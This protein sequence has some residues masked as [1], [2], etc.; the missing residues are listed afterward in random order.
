MKKS[1]MLLTYLLSLTVQAETLN[2]LWI[3]NSLTTANSMPKLLTEVVNKNPTGVRINSV[4]STAGGSDWSFH[5]G[6]PVDAVLKQ[7]LPSPTLP[8]LGKKGLFDWVIIQTV[9][10]PDKRYRFHEFGDELIG[11]IRSTGAEPLIYCAMS[12]SS[13]YKN[14]SHQYVYK[15][16]DREKNITNHEELARRH[17]AV[18]APIGEAWKIAQE[19]RPNFDLFVK[20]GIHPNPIGSYLTV[21]V[22]YSVFTGK[23]PIGIDLPHYYKLQTG[24]SNVDGSTEVTLSDEQATFL[25]ECAQ[26][27]MDE[28]RANGFRVTIWTEK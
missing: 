2:I 28:A 5:L 21:C 15:D 13:G 24:K 11:K 4:M 14:P 25:Q 18:I 26:Q 3:G 16:G 17:N 1:A 20:D 10:F 12:P 22:F 7:R 8:N 27:A 19:K 9:P 23:S 6:K